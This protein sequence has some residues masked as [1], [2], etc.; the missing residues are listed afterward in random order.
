MR[1]GSYKFHI[2]QPACNLKFNPF[3][4]SIHPIQSEIQWYSCLQVTNNII[5]Y[6]QQNNKKRIT[7]NHNLF[8]G[9][10]DFLSH[11]NTFFTFSFA[12]IK[13]LSVYSV[14]K[15]YKNRQITKFAWTQLQENMRLGSS[16][17]KEFKSLYIK[18]TF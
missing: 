14:D 3:N 13:A 12:N 8:F 4:R 6:L 17:Y 7:H 11:G 2:K 9:E 5:D 10:I 1:A 16:G 15:I 18:P